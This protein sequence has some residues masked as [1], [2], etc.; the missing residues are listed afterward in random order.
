MRYYD[1]DES[2]ISRNNKIPYDNEP[3]SRNRTSSSMRSGSK[4]YAPSRTVSILLVVLIAFNIVLGYLVFKLTL[5]TD[6]YSA[7]VDITYVINGES[8]DTTYVASKA[9][10]SA[11]CIA[12]G[13][14]STV[15][16]T[17]ISYENFQ[18]MSDRGA[19]VIIDIDK[20]KGDATIITCE[21]VVSG[22]QD[23]IYILLSDCYKPIK[24][25]Y[26]GG[27]VSRD[28]AV[29]QIYGS[30]ETKKSSSMA[31][32]IADSAY[33]SYGN[34][35]LAVGNPMS[36][37]FDTSAGQIRKPQTLVNVSNIG[38]ERVIATDVPINS[39]NSGGG[40]FNAKGELIGIVNAKI[41]NVSIDNYSYAIPSTLALSIADSIIRNNGIA[42]AG[43][44]GC[45]FMITES[46][47]E[48]QIINGNIIYTD[49]VVAKDIQSGSA[50]DKGGI[51]NNDIILSFSYNESTSVEMI[52]MYSF[53][54]H[55]Y[56]LKKGDKVVF[57]VKRGTSVV[58][59][60]VTIEKLA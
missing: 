29:L 34:P 56:R 2:E 12:S 22:N 33:V 6:N 52:S 39:G 38:Q 43:V 23:S 1:Y 30:N 25:T 24:A 5:S 47:R 26:V 54:D 13:Y 11:V 44:L 57:T 16:A 48:Q 60:V 53:E 37:G 4:N 28:I 9:M 31:A 18:S 36:S 17:N 46:G 7:P 49:T 14:N 15:N 19:G 45:S 59:C 40:L 51:L 42:K 41:E 10:P 27:I 55:A 21:H 35:V 50:A 32:E 58:D 3:I 8:V 20:Q